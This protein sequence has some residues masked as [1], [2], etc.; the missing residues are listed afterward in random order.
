VTLDEDVAQQIRQRMRE[1][2]TG[3][4]ETL[5]EL[6]R[7]GLQ[8]R[9]PAEPYRTPTFDLGVRPD[10]DLDKALRLAAALDDEETLRELER[11]T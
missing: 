11:G 3:F 7:R 10:V 4:K 1:R 6:L 5:N 9:E 2:G 8:S